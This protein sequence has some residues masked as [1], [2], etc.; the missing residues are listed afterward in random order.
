MKN[1]KKAISLLK[2]RA[3]W[4]LTGN[5]QLSG[6]RFAFLSTID[7]DG[8][9]QWGYDASLNRSARFEGEIGVTDLTWET[10]EKIN[11]G[12]ELGLWNAFNLQVDWF[13]EMR[14]DIFMQ[15][16][17]IPTAAG[18]RKT[19]WANFGK[20]NNTGVDLA[21]SFNKD[22]NKNL[23]IGFRGTFTYAHNTIIEQD[24][25]LG[26]I[27]TNRQRTGHS[28][29][30]LFGLKAV[31]LFT[32]EDFV[33]GPN[34]ELTLRDDIP[35]H[36]FSTVRPGD[37]RYEDVNNDGVVNAMDE[38]A[39]GGTVNPEI[40][41]GF[42]GNVRWKNL[43]FS[44]F[45]Q[46]NG[47]TYRFIGGPAANFLPGSSQGTMGNILS[48]YNDRWTE[49]NPSQDVFYPRLSWGPNANNS[50]NSSWWYKDMSML[51]L[52]D[53][54]IGYSL[55]HRWMDKIRLE[56]IRIYLKGSNLATFSNFKLWDPEL[57]TQTGSKYP[58][59]RSVSIGFDINF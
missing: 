56:S 26:V 3:S 19:P 54:E 22:I 23:Y 58:I 30:E 15:R 45:F 32:E 33:T 46:G 34:G 37:I 14:R 29:D 47:K 21:L 28:V 18:F 36:T 52:K 11:V 6:R 55:P 57:D 50:Q 42:G 27:G 44:F 31:G 12:M 20:V 2:F 53:V 4:G 40:V 49:E 7:T 16:Q 5:D 17:N 10:V 24:E 1:V 8:S 51:R 9:Y 41:Y 25:A 13:K 38:V 39:M 48:N 59:M 35:A 43:D